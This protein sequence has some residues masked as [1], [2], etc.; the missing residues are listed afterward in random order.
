MKCSKCG[1]E[2]NRLNHHFV[3]SKKIKE[4]KRLCIKCM[5][6]ENITTLV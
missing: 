3:P 1:A 5:K 4:G 2:I 6:E